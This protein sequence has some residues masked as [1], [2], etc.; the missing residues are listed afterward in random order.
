[1][2]KNRTKTTIPKI[3]FYRIYSTAT[4]ELQIL[5]GMAGSLGKKET[6][7]LYYNVV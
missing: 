5:V 1:L 7:F 2:E 4:N 6:S 3:V